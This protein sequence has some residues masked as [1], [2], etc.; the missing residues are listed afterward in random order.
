[1]SGPRHLST[2]LN[3]TRCVITEML[4]NRGFDVSPIASFT[5]FNSI[6]DLEEMSIKLSKNNNEIIQVHYE[7][8]KTRTNHKQLTK[9]IE[10]IV[11]TH[12]NSPTDKSKDLTIVFI[13]CDG[14]TPSVKEAVRLLSTKYNVFI[15]I[16]PIRNLMYNV[17]K[18]KAVPQHI[19]IPKTEYASYLTEFLDSLHIDSLDKL[20]KILDTDPIAMFI[21]LR[22]GEMCKIIRPSMSAGKHIVYRYCVAEK[23]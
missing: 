13:V 19:R 8:S 11:E 1:M 23:Y 9:R 21:G 18:H 3:N 6:E 4:E 2:Y 20:P 5:P 15:Q 7:V 14:M 17:T 10:H 16:F 12:N 22:P